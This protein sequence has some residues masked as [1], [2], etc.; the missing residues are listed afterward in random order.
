MVEQS[1]DYQL[2]MP[3]LRPVTCSSEGGYL[4]GSGRG[5]I[6]ALFRAY[7]PLPRPELWL[8]YVLESIDAAADFL[9]ESLRV[10]SG[11]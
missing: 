11:G 3:L 6:A 9:G 1:Q 5:T 4:R 7:G 2:A 8:P 10:E